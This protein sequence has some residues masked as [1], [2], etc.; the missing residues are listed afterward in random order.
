MRGLAPIGDSWQ[1]LR[2]C[3]SYFADVSVTR[4]DIIWVLDVPLMLLHDHARSVPVD[5]DT[6]ILGPHL[7]VL[8]VVS[9]EANI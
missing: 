3:A 2:Y 9:A 5:R 7:L 6:A 8:T 1:R 4:E